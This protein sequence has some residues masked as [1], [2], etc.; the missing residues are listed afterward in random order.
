MR[1]PEADPFRKAR[2]REIARDIVAK[3]RSD[4]KHGFAV[5]TAGAIARAIERAYRQGF[6]DAQLGPMPKAAIVANTEETIDWTL[7]PPRPRNAFWSI[8]LFAIGRED[9]P[10]RTG[11]LVPAVTDRG[12]PGWQLIV[13]ERSLIEKT[14]GEKTIIPLIRLGLLDLAD[15]TVERLIISDLGKATWRIFLQRGGRFPEDLISV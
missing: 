10:Q 3:D 4:R 1:K 9:E 12:T 11:Y 6:E 13:P 14:I 15:G 8:C 2:F 7:I 5:D